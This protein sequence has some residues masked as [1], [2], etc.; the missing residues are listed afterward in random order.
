M[1][2]L[3]CAIFAV[4]RG[5]YDFESRRQPIL[6]VAAAIVDGEVIKENTWYKCVG[7]KF[8]EIKE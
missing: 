1:G 7:G 8:V 3:G 5:E 6:S 2:S 4:E